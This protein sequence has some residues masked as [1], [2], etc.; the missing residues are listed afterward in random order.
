VGSSHGP[1]SEK[2]ADQE[3][4]EISCKDSEDTIKLAFFTPSADGKSWVTPTYLIHL[5]DKVADHVECD[6]CN[7]A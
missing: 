5:P 7:V 6:F 2:L 1:A 3:S 4:L